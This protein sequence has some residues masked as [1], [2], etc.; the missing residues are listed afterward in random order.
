MDSLRL[1][2]WNTSSIIEINCVSE[3]QTFRKIIVYLVSVIY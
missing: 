2:A 3:K 1:D